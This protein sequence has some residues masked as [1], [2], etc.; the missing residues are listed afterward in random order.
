MSKE[1]TTDTVVGVVVVG[2]I[3]AIA[4]Y[5]LGGISFLTS[6]F[7]WVAST[8]LSVFAW[9]ATL[10]VGSV[11]QWVVG[12]VVLVVLAVLAQRYFASGGKDESVED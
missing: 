9:V 1:Q 12:A 10:V 6:A 2:L 4:V 8:S 7:S 3:A 5:F 11:I